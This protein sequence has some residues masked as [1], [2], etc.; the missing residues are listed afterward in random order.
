MTKLID[1]MPAAAKPTNVLHT[2][3]IMTYELGAVVSGLVYADLKRSW[4]D[5]KGARIREVNA[6]INLADLIT[7]CRV[8]AEQMNWPWLTLLKDGEERFFERMKEI[9]EGKL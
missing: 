8:L 4:G 7:Q 9:E 1:E 3:N 2:C 6:R 5:D